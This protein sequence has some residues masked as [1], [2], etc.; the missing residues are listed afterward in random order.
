VEREKVEQV[1]LIR[2][3]YIEP[4]VL[5]EPIVEELKSFE[6][7]PK[8]KKKVRR[9]MISSYYFFKNNYYFYNNNETTNYNYFKLRGRA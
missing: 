6:Q 4:L 7:E 5:H 2:A 1:R 8:K 9:R 3:I